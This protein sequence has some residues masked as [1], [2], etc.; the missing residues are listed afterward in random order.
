MTCISWAK[1]TE[2]Y[3]KRPRVCLF[4]HSFGWHFPAACPYSLFYRTIVV[5]N[6]NQNKLR[7]RWHTMT[8]EV[9]NF[10]HVSI[11][12]IYTAFIVFFAL[13]YNLW[14]FSLL[15]SVSLWSGR[16]LNR[17]PIS[18]RT[19]EDTES[20]QTSHVRDYWAYCHKNDF[21]FWFTVLFKWI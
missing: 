1:F 16:K 18:I 13:L 15:G 11:L 8:T 17:M 7:Q 10:S 19:W 2:D 4:W 21:V 6:V 3:L 5:Y 9:N 14:L 20:Y 12:Y